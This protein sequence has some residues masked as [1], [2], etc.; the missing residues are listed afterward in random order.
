MLP[1]LQAQSV[2]IFEVTPLSHP[3]LIKMTERELKGDLIN[4]PFWLIIIY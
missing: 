3:T 2:Q 4:F 1:C